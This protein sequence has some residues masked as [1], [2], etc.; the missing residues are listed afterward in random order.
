[1]DWETPDK[2]WIA[3]LARTSWS[4]VRVTNLLRISDIELRRLIALYWPDLRPPT[5]EALHKLLM[6]QHRLKCT[7]HLA[8]PE[9]P[10]AGEPGEPVP[11][12]DVADDDGL[13]WAYQIS[14]VK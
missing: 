6:P 11:V 12:A 1:M 3:K 13:I 9:D 14:S 5:L 8:L 10:C 4:V 2:N 7:I